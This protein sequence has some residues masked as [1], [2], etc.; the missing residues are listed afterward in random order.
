MS[1]ASSRVLAEPAKSYPACTKAVTPAG[2]TEQAHQKYIAAKQDYDEG[3]YDYAIRRFRDAYS[4]DCNQHELLLIISATYEKKGDRKEALTALETYQQRLPN[5]P[6]ATTV[7]AKIENLKKQ[8]AAAAPAPAPTPLAATPPAPASATET[9]EHTILPWF[10]V[11]VGV[12]AVGAGIV[13][14]VAAPD[15]PAD[16]EAGTCT[17]VKGTQTEDAINV[18][19]RAEAGRHVGMTTGGVI[20][21]AGGGALVV[22][23]LLWHFLE[24][25]GPKQASLT[26]PRVAPSVAP[27]FAGLSLS[28]AFYAF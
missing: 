17:D 21:L 26:R 6:D 15:L 12:A 16:C 9:Q 22:G 8:I 11:G 23:G 28:G 7:Q 1:V 5:A 13:L 24:P 2:D 14:L 18:D 3:N 27:G 20:T 25:T 4:L 10:V 19:R